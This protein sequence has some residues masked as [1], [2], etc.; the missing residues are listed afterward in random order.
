M[1]KNTDALMAADERFAAN[2]K[3]L[4]EE[5]GW[6]QGELA[7]RLRDA[8]L[9]S[10]HPTTVVRMEK[11]ERLVRLGEA[12]VIAD[13]LG[14]L[15]GV[16][17]APGREG[18]V[19][20]SLME[21]VNDF[22]IARNALEDAASMLALERQILQRELNEVTASD[23]EEWADDDLR[24]RIGTVVNRARLELDRPDWKAVEAIRHG[25]PD[26]EA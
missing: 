17:V 5:R 1:A 15:V 26:E 23:Y 9:E 10:F 2:V 20:Q 25:Q 21:R 16:M 18:L 19:A 8:G 7:S 4:R 22:A 3:A 24:A 6:S 11:G 12:R 13:V 14:T